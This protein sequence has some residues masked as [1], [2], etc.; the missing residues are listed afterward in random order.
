MNKQQMLDELRDGA[1]TVSF[2]K[3]N[4][5]ARVM[6]CTLVEA[7]I[8]VGAKSKGTGKTMSDETIAVFA[9]DIG[10][11][12][13]FRVDGVTSFVNSIGEELHD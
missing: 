4:G 3:V 6:P 9:T 11:W 10:E 7:N 1:C 13:S 12:R 8:P 2:T 5:D